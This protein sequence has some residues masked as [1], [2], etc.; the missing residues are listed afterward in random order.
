MVLTCLAFSDLARNL[1][2]TV[3]VATTVTGTPGAGAAAGAGVGI[4]AAPIYPF[5]SF[6]FS[7]GDI[8][9]EAEGGLIKCWLS[10][11]GVMLLD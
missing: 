9:R 5:P 1:V 8:P 2:K 3:G 4:R 7:L 11:T 6:F 10:V